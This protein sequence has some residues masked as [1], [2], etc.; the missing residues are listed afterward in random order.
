[1]TQTAKPDKRK[2]RAS[3]DQRTYP[4]HD[5]P[6]PTPDDIRRELGWGLIPHSDDTNEQPWPPRAIA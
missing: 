2:V 4:E 1:M 6:P 5:D 3:M